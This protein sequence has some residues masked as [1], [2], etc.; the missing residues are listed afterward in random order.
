MGAKPPGRS[1]DYVKGDND[2]IHCWAAGK[3]PKYIQ[4]VVTG[5][6]WKIPRD[7][8]FNG[9]VLPNG[10]PC[11]LVQGAAPFGAP[12]PRHC[13]WGGFLISSISPLGEWAYQYDAFDGAN[14]HFELALT[15][16]ATFFQGLAPFT[17]CKTQWGN[18]VE[19]PVF[20]GTAYMEW[21]QSVN[22]QRQTDQANYQTTDRPSVILRDHKFLDESKNRY[23]QEFAEDGTSALY[24]RNRRYGMSMQ[25][26]WDE[27]A[28]QDS[29]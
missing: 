2:C 14:A 19:N 12:P 22:A 16:F 13:V 6:Q 28:Y 15:G 7:P 1:N 10:I 11:V 26:K 21:N 18:F 27:Q 25:V 8:I 4:A 23:E 20:G 5:M 29:L 17:A 3:T 9:V 24:L